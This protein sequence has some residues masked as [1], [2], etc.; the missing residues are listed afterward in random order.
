MD[1]EKEAARQPIYR[2]DVVDLGL[3]PVQLPN[4]HRLALEV[5]R[6]PGGA[7]V[8]A[9]NARQEICLLRQWRHAGGGWLWELPA[10]KLER[11]EPALQTAQR[12][13]EEEAGLRATQWQVLGQILTT[14]GF[15]DEVIHLYLAQD[16]QSVTARPQAHESIE[17]HWQP[18]SQALDWARQGIIRDAKT[19]LGLFYAQAQL[20]A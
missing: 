4:G 6:H 16:L 20:E 17:V 11:G 7:A 13:L 9:L 12:E 15:C 1:T 3:E 2:G 8:V 19:L 14:P 18:F 10:G 5:I